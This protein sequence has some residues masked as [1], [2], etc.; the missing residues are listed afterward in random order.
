MLSSKEI[1][2]SNQIEKLRK[3][4]EAENKKLRNELE[5][6]QQE[7]QE[8]LRYTVSQKDEDVKKLIESLTAENEV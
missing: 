7:Y 8:K 2:S 5:A 6:V 3:E 1:E 4:V